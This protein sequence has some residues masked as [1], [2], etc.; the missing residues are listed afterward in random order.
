M[1]IPEACGL[2]IEQRVKEELERRGD[3]G[4]S[5]RE[6]GRQVASEVEKYFETKVNPDTIRK[7]AERINGTNVPQKETQANSSTSENL[8]KLEKSWGGTREGS[9]RKPKE[10]PE[11]CNVEECKPEEVENKNIITFDAGN[12]KDLRE[13]GKFLAEKI[14]SGEA[15]PLVGSPVST[16]VKEAL[17]KGVKPEPK[18]IN[19]FERLSKHAFAL[20]EG[21]TFWAD[22]TMRPD[23]EQ[24][25]LEARTVID[26][27]VSI[28]V[29][30]SRIGVNVLSIYEMFIDPKRR[31]NKN[32]KKE[33]AAGN[34]CQ[35]DRLFSR[36]ES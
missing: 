14:N 28:I 27:A 29:Q 31:D 24:E 34:H 6:I 26:C 33:I 16:A 30:Y 23:S 13:M 32:G 36:D 17:K 4:A 5:L 21:L 8:E 2:W 22:G 11:Q 18:P 25:A 9:G 15:K 35:D 19:N 20:N 1:A 10:K 12:E 7:R 3:T